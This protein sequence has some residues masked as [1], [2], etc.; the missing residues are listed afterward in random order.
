M[1]L[2]PCSAPLIPS[3]RPQ[4]MLSPVLRPTSTPAKHSGFTAVLGALLLS[5]CQ[6][7][8]L[9]PGGASSTP[10]EP[11]PA[12]L[13]EAMAPSASV[14]A[15]A[16]ELTPAGI[17]LR[18]RG[19]ALF[20]AREDRLAFETWLP[21]A[22]A[23]HP[24]TQFNIGVLLTRSSA[25]PRDLAAAR[26]WQQLASDAG[27][28]PAHCALGD[29]LWADRADPLNR[30]R[31][32]AAYLKGANQNEVGCMHNAAAFLL[33]GLAGAPD[34]LAGL[35]WLERSAEL[36]NLASQAQLGSVHLHGRYSPPE[37]EHALRWLTLASDRGHV[38]ATH[39][40]AYMW[41]HGLG[42]QTDLSIAAT[43]YERAAA[44]GQPQSAN[45]LGLMYRNGQGVP[46]DAVKAVG[47]FEQAVAKRNSEAMVNLGDMHYLG[48]GVAP[49]AARAAA[50]YQ[51]AANA[52]LLWGDCRLASLM[53]HGEG[54]P[55]DLKQ[56]DTLTQRVQQRL[57]SANCVVPLSQ[58]LR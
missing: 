30:Q 11:I 10:A 39:D 58:L 14:L 20:E 45:N 37:H 27:Y 32:L 47:Y 43:L 3:Y 17:A 36:G 5:A 49:D 9:P 23:G 6:V 26:R 2:P 29:L 42:T 1:R 25:I 51:Q 34:V 38:D 57:P 53:R 18:D 31:A 54:V 44:A 56:A 46:R 19:V 13:P 41:E 40:L 33:N 16:G 28:A 55:L 35:H 22:E 15:I 4:P 50:L 21:L 12:P 24:E 7:T 48:L 52:G 8:P